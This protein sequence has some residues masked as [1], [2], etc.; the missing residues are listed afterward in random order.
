MLL[1][2]YKESLLNYPPNSINLLI[3]QMLY[4]I[5]ITYSVMLNESLILAKQSN[6]RISNILYLRCLQPI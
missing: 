4:F 2:L 1:N 6:K 3:Q 5:F